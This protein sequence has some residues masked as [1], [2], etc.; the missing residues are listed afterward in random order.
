MCKFKAENKS[1]AISLHVLS[2][3][4]SVPESVDWE[5]KSKV[6]ISLIQCF[7]PWLRFAQCL[8]QFWDS[9]NTVHLLNAGKYSTVFLMVTFAG[10]YNTARGSSV[11]INIQYLMLKDTQCQWVSHVFFIMFMVISL[12]IYKKITIPYTLK[13]RHIRCL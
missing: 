7:S 8:R 4:V 3:F 13:K 10:L 5:R 1:C 11:K 12:Y 9:G 2:L 6:V